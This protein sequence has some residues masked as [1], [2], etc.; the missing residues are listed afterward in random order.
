MAAASRRAGAPPERSPEWR[1]RAAR[2]YLEL[3]RPA[4]AMI[5]RAFRGAFGD[6]EIEDIS[7]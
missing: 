4:R 3:R 6:D 1:P 7:A 5:R 2:L